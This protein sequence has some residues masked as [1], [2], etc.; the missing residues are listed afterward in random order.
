MITTTPIPRSPR[1]PHFGPA[2]LPPSNNLGH[3][4]QN[5]K[6]TV[7]ESTDDH[8]SYEPE[9]SVNTFSDKP[10]DFK[11]KISVKPM[12]QEKAFRKML[13]ERCCPFAIETS[14]Q[15]KQMKSVLKDSKNLIKHS[16]NQYIKTLKSAKSLSVGRLS[17]QQWVKL[18]DG[19]VKSPQGERL[20]RKAVASNLAGIEEF[21]R[22]EGVNIDHQSSK[23]G[24]TPLIAAALNEHW[25]MVLTL[26]DSGAKANML[27]N[28][29]SHIL[30]LIF[31]ASSKIKRKSI[32]T[33][34]I[35]TL[36]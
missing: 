29:G 18:L 13:I 31:K 6:V 33:N 32:M 27:N 23:S 25:N 3:D 19:F 36:L 16:V 20:Y 9:L 24:N 28:D 7:A 30:E 17:E 12:S 1:S 15:T 2:S 35:T 8:L 22:S 14:Q 21:L 4:R 11:G 5:R 34:L 10:V 26:I